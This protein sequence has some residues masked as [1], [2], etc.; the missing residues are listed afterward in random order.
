VVRWG[1]GRKVSRGV[2]RGSKDVGVDVML[3]EKEIQQKAIKNPLMQ[4]RAALS[5][6]TASLN[7]G[8][9]MARMS[10]SRNIIQ[11]IHYG[12]IVN[13]GFFYFPMQT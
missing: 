12:R 4:P 2:E 7:T 13:S 6:L 9:A 8:S 5:E 3:K 10:N 11:K 1:G